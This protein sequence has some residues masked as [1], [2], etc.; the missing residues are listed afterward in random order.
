VRRIFPLSAAVIAA[1]CG[2]P[3]AV[4]VPDHAVSIRV[5]DFRYHPQ[6]VR[7]QAGAITFHVRNGGRLP[8]NFA[9][10]GEG[11]DRLQVS[12]MLPGETDQGIVNLPPG[13]YRMYCTIGNHEEL[14][15]YGTLIITR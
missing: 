13:Q 7:V 14:G 15:E 3:A 9:I 4:T 6:V 10:R 8:H 1:G 11:S 2:S 12:T 5:T